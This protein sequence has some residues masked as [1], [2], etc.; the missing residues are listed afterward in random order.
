MEEIHDNVASHNYLYQANMKVRHGG[1]LR[2]E[3][4]VWKAAPYVQGVTGAVKH[5][6]SPK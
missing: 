5:K 1:Q 3:E 4:L 2:E 6:F